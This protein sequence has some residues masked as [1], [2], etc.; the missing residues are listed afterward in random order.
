MAMITKLTLKR[1]KG[2]EDFSVDLGRFTVLVGRNGAGKTSI[3]EALYS[4]Q[5]ALRRLFGGKETPQFSQGG[6]PTRIG[7]N[8]VLRFGVTA[9][10][11]ESLWF[12]RQLAKD[13]KIRA[14]YTNG[15]A[16]EIE[17]FEQ[18]LLAPALFNPRSNEPIRQLTPEDKAAIE[19][20]YPLRPELLR[21]V[22]AFP[23][24]ETRLRYTDVEAE[25]ARGH[26]NSVWRNLMW[27][28]YDADKEGFRAALSR[29]RKRL[30][31][32]YPE[33]PSILPA[34]DTV[35][36]NYKEE[37]IKY[38]I[39]SG[40][41]G[42]TTLLSVA[43]ATELAGARLILLDEPDAHLH[44]SLQAEVAK[45][46]QEMTEQGNCQIIV[47]T[48]APDFIDSVPPDS[49]RWVDRRRQS[50]ESVTS[51]TRL[52]ERL[53][54]LTKVHA[55]QL[56]DVRVIL[57]LEGRTDLELLD[58]VAKKLG[59]EHIFASPALEAAFDLKEGHEEYLGGQQKLL[60]RVLDREVWI[61]A[62]RDADYRRLAESAPRQLVVKGNDEAR[63][64]ILGKKEI[65]NYFLEPEAI[66]SAYRALAEGN[67]SEASSAP[68]DA[69]AVRDAIRE[70]AEAQVHERM[71]HKFIPLQAE[72]QGSSGKMP[73]T[74]HQ[75]AEERYEELFRD[76]EWL[77][78]SIPGKEALRG[79]NSR[80]EESTGVKLSV[81]DICE[82][83]EPPEDLV[84]ILDAVEEALRAVQNE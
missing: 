55:L 54:S 16:F 7:L 6:V 18:S 40:G 69:D 42:L 47:A 78:D 15:F 59:K 72:R 63:L 71:K 79:L 82:H 13:L 21:P 50:G 4:V 56:S 51:T 41:G 32:A 77:L 74:K 57:W 17:S 64:F 70:W 67:V 44:S 35:Q 81:L 62:V 36:I 38:D 84:K 3:L 48:H 53:G 37:G 73:E 30:P 31:W 22:G 11:S 5:L 12:Q 49:L 33:E 24:L 45:G 23:Q 46:L 9:S 61:V 1:F 39:S 10:Q 83:M 34:D 25:I 43:V 80:F 52:M 65:E 28:R 68:P 76:D 26:F 14:S 29:L 2:F 58:K 8:D 20:I 60:S 75:E 27:W 19:E 66:A